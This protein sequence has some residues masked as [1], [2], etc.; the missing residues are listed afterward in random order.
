MCYSENRCR[1]LPLGY[2]FKSFDWSG[3]LAVRISAI[4]M[5]RFSKNNQILIIRPRVQ[6]SEWSVYDKVAMWLLL[7]QNGLSHIDLRY[8]HRGASCIVMLRDK[9]NARKYE[10]Q[11]KWLKKFLYN[12]LPISCLLAILCTLLQLSLAMS[13]CPRDKRTARRKWDDLFWTA[14]CS[15]PRRNTLFDWCAR[16]PPPEVVYEKFKTDNYNTT[17]LPLHSLANGTPID[18]S[19]SVKGKGK[20]TVPYPEGPFDVQAIPKG[21]YPL[22]VTTLP[23]FYSPASETLTHRYLLVDRREIE[24]KQSQMDL[25]PQKATPRMWSEVTTIVHAVSPSTQYSSS[26]SLLDMEDSDL[27]YDPFGTVYPTWMRNL[28]EDRSEADNYSISNIAPIRREPPSPQPSVRSTSGGF[29]PPPQMVPLSPPLRS[30]PWE[31]LPGPFVVDPNIAR[32]DVSTD[33][34]SVYIFHPPNSYHP[35]FSPTVSPPS[36]VDDLVI[37]S[38]LSLEG[39]LITPSQDHPTE[40]TCPRVVGYERRLRLTAA[41][42]GS[43]DVIT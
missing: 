31:S 39:S 7:W 6:V 32:R 25:E 14:R 33:A 12:N 43:Q 1:P 35:I 8:S 38:S 30:R 16:C 29:P 41:Q 42:S 18:N 40:S 26:V 34:N 4:A 9:I 11:T 22:E 2:L 20:G 36:A 5:S 10:H 17:V 37:L 24:I 27:P 23:A 3:T 21:I 19:L 15:D 28:L 13:L